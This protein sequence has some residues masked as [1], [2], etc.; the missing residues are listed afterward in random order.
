MSPVNSARYATALSPIA[1]VIR[2]TVAIAV[3][4]ISVPVSRIAIRIRRGVDRVTGTVG[5]VTTV[6]WITTIGWVTRANVDA[7][8]L[9]GSFERHNHRQA[10]R[11]SAHKN[12]G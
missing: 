1:A 6:G 2:P 4:R 11:D 3:T 5:W 10:K 8:A 7:N 12:G 9:C